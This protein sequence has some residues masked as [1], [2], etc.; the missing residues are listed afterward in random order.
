M[1]SVITNL[2]ALM[3]VHLRD[4]SLITSYP[5]G[6]PGYIIEWLSFDNGRSP[7]FYEGYV[8]CMCGPFDELL[9]RVCVL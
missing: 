6:P 4:D 5:L 1:T 2:P 7:I 8:V 9:V 3:R